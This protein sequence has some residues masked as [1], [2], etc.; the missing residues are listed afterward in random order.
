MFKYSIYYLTMPRQ[1]VFGRPSTFSLRL[2]LLL[3][4]LSWMPSPAAA[5]IDEREKTERVADVLAALALK[6][7]MRVAD[8]GAGDGFYTLKIAAAIAPGRVTGG[9]ISEKALARMRQHLAKTAL[10]NV[11]VLL[12]KP[13]DPV[14]PADSFDAILIH[15]AYHEFVEHQKMLGHMHNALKSTGR[16]VLVEPFGD[17]PQLPRADQVAN[18]RIDIN[19]AA[20]ELAEANFD[21][22]DRQEKF[23]TFP[24]DAQPKNPKGEAHE[25]VGYFGL[26]GARKLIVF[27]Q[28]HTESFVVQYVWD[29][30]STSTRVV[31]VSEAIENIPKGYRA[32]ETYVQLGPDEFEEI[33]E[34][35][36]PGK[37]YEVYSKS[38]LKRV[39]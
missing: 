38:R 18:H 14:L 36:A 34:M 10:T 35:A 11:D 6:P 31:M 33:F 37:D 24:N 3:V 28:F 8:I 1:A 19:I 12:G 16:L 23:I 15:N 39:K 26:D 2:G 32:R 13:D 27:L 20:R 29:S 5:Q 7:G 22:L 30:A 21:V 25:D 17:K 9:D 4:A